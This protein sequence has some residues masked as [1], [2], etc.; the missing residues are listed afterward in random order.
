MNTIVEAI[1]DGRRRRRRH[2]EEF[3]AE[4][5]KAAR[6]PGVSIAAVALA[7]GLNANLLRRW[8][9]EHE[10]SLS[11]GPVRH[12]A[13]ELTDKPKR[14]APIESFLPVRVHSSSLTGAQIRIELK[15]GRTAISASW[16]IEA[17]SQCAGWLRKLL[18]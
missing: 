10:R 7:H 14:S 2:S 17:A 4:V 11:H 13:I 16:P 15:H 1:T 9:V 5:V 8:V 3:K 18:R 12:R 6:V